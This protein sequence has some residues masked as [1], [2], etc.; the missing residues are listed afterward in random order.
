MHTKPVP[1]LGSLYLLPAENTLPQISTW[2]TSSHG[3]I[4]PLRRSDFLDCPRSSCFSNIFGSHRPLIINQKCQS[5]KG[6]QAPCYPPGG[7]RVIHQQNYP[8]S[9]LCVCVFKSTV[10]Q[11]L[12]SSNM[13][14]WTRSKA[15]ESTFLKTYLGITDPIH[16]F[17]FFFRGELET[18]GDEVVLLKAQWVHGRDELSDAEIMG[19]KIPRSEMPLLCLV[20]SSKFSHVRGELKKKSVKWKN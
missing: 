15:Q 17:D 13:A 10:S 4:L 6:L 18:H 11:A 8:R 20:L 7:S 19:E 14:Q 2:L 16:H 3:K 12:P 9:S 1:A 5:W